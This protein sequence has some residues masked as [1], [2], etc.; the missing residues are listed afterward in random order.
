MPVTWP[1]TLPQ[2][3]EVSGNS[4]SFPDLLTGF[5]PDH[6]PS[7]I[8]QWGTANEALLAGQ[9]T[10]TAAQLDILETFYKANCGEEITFPNQRGGAS[11]LTV[12]FINGKP[13]S[14]VGIGAGLF[15]VQLQFR[16]KP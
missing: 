12:N 3:F 4:G 1:A 11:P 5:Q 16:V 13:P 7:V 15:T 6:G 9:M 8:R 2:H 14:F 10:M